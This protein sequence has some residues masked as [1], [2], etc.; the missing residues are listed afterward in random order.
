M[1]CSLSVNLFIFVKKS[2]EFDFLKKH[3]F[4]PLQLFTCPSC[5]S[6]RLNREEEEEEWL[7]QS[8]TLM[9]RMT[10]K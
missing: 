4:P 10:R 1:T 7:V 8:K 9:V 3:G 5:I 6:D 2:T